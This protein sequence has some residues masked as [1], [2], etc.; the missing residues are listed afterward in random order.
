VTT[1]RQP[2]ATTRLGNYDLA[3]WPDWENQESLLAS[4]EAIGADE[5]LLA[6]YA[7]RMG[8]GQPELIASPFQASSNL[9]SFIFTCITWESSN[10][11]GFLT[12]RDVLGYAFT[13]SPDRPVSCNA[14]LRRVV[15]EWNARPLGWLA[16]AAGYTPE[17]YD[18]LDPQ[19]ATSNLVLLAGLRNPHLPVNAL[20]P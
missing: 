15:R 12:A 16:A 3:V 20:L 8:S 14:A 9:A 10:P 7:W 1:D 18:A 17:E 2:I 19:P 13:T 11:F 6:Y 5:A 4:C